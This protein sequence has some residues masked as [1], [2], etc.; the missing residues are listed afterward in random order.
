MTSRPTR[1]L[2]LIAILVIGFWAVF[3]GQASPD[4][5]KTGNSVLDRFSQEQRERLE[6]GEVI[7]EYVLDDTGDSLK[8]H[9]RTSILINAPLDECFRI[10]LDFGKQYLYLPRMTVS[11]VLKSEGNKTLIYK[12]LDYTLKTIKYTHILTIYPGDHRVDFQDVEEKYDPDNPKGYFRFQRVDDETT[13]FS[14][15]LL[16][17]DL[18]FP[19]P[20]SIKKYMTSKDLPGI[21]ISIKKRI[22]SR[23][24]WEK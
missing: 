18:G 9:G 7:F 20:E 21:A 1:F 6:K 10:F 11:K 14:Y 22:E 13:L 3:S 4:S 23:G 5:E 16:R 12:E 8:G 17:L 2:S 24:K 15:A 19:V